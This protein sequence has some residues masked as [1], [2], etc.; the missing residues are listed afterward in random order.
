MENNKIIISLSE[1]ENLIFERNT[2][3]GYNEVFVYVERNG[4]V[5]QDLA[6]IGQNYK[7]DENMSVH[8]EDGVYSIRVFGDENNEDFT[9]EFIIERREDD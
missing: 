6:I 8:N 3:P 2:D 9:E 5:W 7:Y 4:I 1:D